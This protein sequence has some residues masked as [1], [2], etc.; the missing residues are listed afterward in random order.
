MQSPMKTYM[1]PQE[2]NSIAVTSMEIKTLASP[3][4]TNQTLHVG[5]LLQVAHLS[6]VQL[7]FSF[8]K[9][10]NKPVVVIYSLLVLLKATHKY[11]LLQVLVSSTAE[12]F[13]ELWPILTHQNVMQLVKILSNTIH[14]NVWQV[15]YY[16]TASAKSFCSFLIRWEKQSG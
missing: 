13:H 16:P 2:S 1:I 5:K 10:A 9:S 12:Y 6:Q 4:E 11:I 7:F 14:Q 8:F 15:I 3:W